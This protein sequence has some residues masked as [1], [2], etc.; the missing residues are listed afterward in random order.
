MRLAQIEKAA[1]LMRKVLSDR[2]EENKTYLSAMVAPSH[3][4]LII[5]LAALNRVKQADVLRA[6]IDEWCTLKLE[7]I[8]TGGE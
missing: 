1:R 5:E 4:E 7:E 8:E 6:M 2:G 3:K